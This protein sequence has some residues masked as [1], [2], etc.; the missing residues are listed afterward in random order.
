VVDEL[1]TGDQP[2][3]ASLADL[4]L[5]DNL[6]VLARIA[7]DRIQR[8]RLDSL[9]IDAVRRRLTAIPVRTGDVIVVAGADNLSAECLDELGRQTRLSGIR[10]VL[11]MERLTPTAAG[12]LGAADNSAVLMRLGNPVEAGH[13]A[14]FIGPGYRWPTPPRMWP[15]VP[16]Q[17]PHTPEFV[18]DPA[19]LQRMPPTAFVAVHARAGANQRTVFFGDCDLTIGAEPRATTAGAPAVRPL[20]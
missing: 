2:T 19:N 4:W 16:G 3:G 7:D 5:T 20:A 11:M 18:L 9:L 13:A 15:Q 8:E 14:R 12:M 17:P 6:T 10:L 1:A